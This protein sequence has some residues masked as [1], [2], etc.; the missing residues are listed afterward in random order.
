MEVL[1]RHIKAIRQDQQGGKVAVLT[2]RCVLTTKA[3]STSNQKQSNQHGP[4][5]VGQQQPQTLTSSSVA[6]AAACSSLRAPVIQQVETL[7]TLLLLVLSDGLWPGLDLW[8]VLVALERPQSMHFR[9][10]V[11]MVLLIRTSFASAS[12]AVKS[13]AFI[14]CALNQGCLLAAL[15]VLGRQFQPIL[16]GYMMDHALLRQYGTEKWDKLVRVIASVAGPPLDVFYTPSVS[17]GSNSPSVAGATSPKHSAPTSGIAFDLELVVPELDFLK[18]YMSTVKLFIGGVTDVSSPPE[19]PFQLVE[20]AAEEAEEVAAADTTSDD[21]QLFVPSPSRRDDEAALVRQSTDG[22]STPSTPAASST[23]TELFPS[24]AGGGDVGGGDEEAGPLANGGAVVAG[25]K[26][27]TVKKVVVVTKRIV[28]KTA[29]GGG[30]AG[31]G[32]TT[33]V[34]TTTRTRSIAPTPSA[35][36]ASVPTQERGEIVADATA[37]VDDVCVEEEPSTDPDAVAGALAMSTPLPQYSPHGQHHMDPVVEL[38]AATHSGA[39]IDSITEDMR[40]E[41]GSAKLHDAAT[42]I[43]RSHSDKERST[44]SRELDETLS[45]VERL[46]ARRRAALDAALETVATTEAF[47]DQE[48][49]RR[50]AM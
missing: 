50:K 13:R 8:S 5:E 39:N 45:I 21:A 27:T 23:T 49:S 16:E 6:T 1:A 26:R 48:L 14:R 19:L 31:D 24:V 46:F 25:K 34:T 28:K 3:S 38:G 12:E 9:F 7:V 10:A 42:T 30:G 2:N 47:L 4:T 29:G 35:E 43:D 32:T 37:A 11:Q 18:D 22:T 41:S 15:E 33:V 17:G 20:E 36:D 40:S 44:R